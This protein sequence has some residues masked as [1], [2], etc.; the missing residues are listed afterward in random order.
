[1]AKVQ[2]VLNAGSS[3]LKFQVFVDDGADVPNRLYRGLF[4]G[5]GTDPHFK[6]KDHEGAVV[7]EERWL[8]DTAYGFEEALAYLSDWLA[9]HRGGHQLAA[10]G[11]R[12][13]HGGPNY[14]HAVR[15]TPEIIAELDTLSPLAPLHQPRSLEPIR[16]IARRVPGLPQVAAF[17]TAF[18][19][20]QP[21]IAQAFAIPQSLT[22]AGVK[23]YGFHGLSYAY[24]AT[25]F[26]HVDERLVHGR[27]VAAHLGSGASLGA[28]AASKSIATTMGFSA[29]DGLVM[30]TRCG[31]IDAGVVFYLQRELGMSAPE[32]EHFLYTKCGLLGVSGISNDMR[33]LREKAEAEPSAQRAIDL[34]VYRINR[35]FGSL[36]AALGGI[37]ALVFTAGIGE[38]DAATRAEVIEAARWAGFDLDPEANRS[39]ATRITR[40]SGPQAYVIPTDEEW[41]IVREM[42]AVLAE[43]RQDAGQI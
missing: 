5:L 23:R 42:R 12:V 6:V 27:V 19:R 24:L 36:V 39:G 17:D 41:T 37:D 20:T 4:E 28:Y 7:G 1:M 21:E 31:T 11:H 34:F 35:E 30:G 43:S 33:E 2:L 9:A 18:H 22:D 10:V 29:L 40:G 13:V 38:N 15:L 26:P 32:A 16:I 14:T 3:S 8:H 25:Q